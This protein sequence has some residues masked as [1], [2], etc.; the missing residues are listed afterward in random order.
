MLLALFGLSAYAGSSPWAIAIFA[1]LL[2][3]GFGLVKTPLAATISRLV[4]GQM[5]ASALSMN[6]M[7]FFLGGSF[8]TAVVV[9]L[10]S[11]GGLAG[12]SLNPLHSGEAT[13]FSDGFLLLMIP[14]LAAM[15]LPS[16]LPAMT[17]PERA[18]D[19]AATADEAPLVFQPVQQWTPDYAVP[20]HPECA[21]MASAGNGFAGAFAVESEDPVS[22]P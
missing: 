18:E 19:K 22:T 16:A 11:S 10:A 2:G 6:S 8:G 21:E 3:A 14:V 15:A 20:W 13:G 4:S 7:L 17:R 1:G 5:L 9:A 12:G